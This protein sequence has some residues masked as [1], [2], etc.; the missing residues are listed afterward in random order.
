MKIKHIWSVLCR[1]SIINQDDN[2][3]SLIGVLEELNSTITPM[4]SKLTRPEKLTI[5]FSFEI[6]NYWTKESNEEI[7]MQIKTEVIDPDGKELSNIVNESIFPESVKQL[8][9]RLKA[10]GLTV[11]SSGTYHFRISLKTS[12]DKSYQVIAELPMK[13]TIQIEK[14]TTSSTN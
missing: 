2:T 5:P 8:R 1:E 11:S 12:K 4:D 6:V 14:L 9:T 3:I 13:V 7:K 10:Q